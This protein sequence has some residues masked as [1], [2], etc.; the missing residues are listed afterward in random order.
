MRDGLGSFLV[1]F[2]KTT[3]TII[4]KPEFVFLSLSS[5][6]GLV[7]IFSVPIFTPPD[8]ANHFLR[9][10]QISQGGFTSETENHKT[11]GKL[12]ESILTCLKISGNDKECYYRYNDL[13]KKHFIDFSSSALYSPVAYIPQTIG[14]A[15]SSEISPS[16][17]SM[18]IFG[19]TLNLIAFVLLIFFA[20]KEA[21]IGKWTYV[22][23][24]LFPVAIQQAAS[25]SSDV[26]TI[27]VCLLWIALISRMYIGINK[28]TRRDYVLMAALAIA[29]ALTKQTNLLL[30]SGVLFLPRQIF[31]N[32]KQRAGV[33]LS[34]LG[35]GLLS[36]ALWYMVMKLNH[37]N[38]GI[39]LDDP[40]INP[41]AQLAHIIHSPL[42][43]ASA[44]V[45]TYFYSSNNTI[46]DFI[47][48]SM[49]SFFSNFS[50]KLPLALCIIGYFGLILSF[51]YDHNRQPINRKKLSRLTAVSLVLFLL[52]I[53][54]VAAALYLEWTPVGLAVIN[55]IQGRYFIPI[56][57][58]LVPLFVM[59]RRYVSLNLK[60]EYTM[61]TITTLI[62]GMN[63]IAMIV[64]TIKWF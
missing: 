12:P 18:V 10:V 13:S 40:T 30:L 46:S 39:N 62:S 17:Y 53:I 56:I 50:Y 57:P 6:A 32:T 16:I 35:I 55:G 45:H 2:K 52:S 1:S 58:L 44:L 41:S 33:V 54:A 3:L 20:I 7:M 29:L 21:K 15:I 27:G 4:K 5:V 26:M 59:A 22:V 9:I 37:Y 31:T 43:F 48:V 25:L 51:L 64:L 63:L 28:I 14:V 36:A 11:G 47:L 49:H 38:M 61:G 8:E 60:N 34:I 24:G 42:S 23:I 19:R